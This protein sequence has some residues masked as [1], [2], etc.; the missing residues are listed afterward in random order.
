M[1][2][3]TV[4]QAR[5]ERNGNTA[6]ECWRSSVVNQGDNMSNIIITLSNT[7]FFRLL[8]HAPEELQREAKGD[9]GRAIPAFCFTEEDIRERFRQEE[10]WDEMS[11]DEQREAIQSLMD[12]VEYD[13]VAKLANGA[14]SEAIGRY[15]HDAM[16][17][18]EERRE[19]TEGS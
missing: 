12:A 16:I 19:E 15:L 18:E 11:E 8:A 5:R 7:I 1:A 13:N 6:P 2:R 17:A 10:Q 4:A 3:R 9:A 14:I